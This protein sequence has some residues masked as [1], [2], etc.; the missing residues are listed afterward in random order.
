MPQIV[1]I[2]TVGG[3]RRNKNDSVEQMSSGCCDPDTSPADRSIWATVDR[4]VLERQTKALFAK[5]HVAGRYA[6]PLRPD[7]E[8]DSSYPIPYEVEKSLADDLAFIA[9]AQPQVQYVTAVALEQSQSKPSLVIRLAA[10]EG[11]SL[12]VRTKFEEIRNVLAK[13]ARKGD[14]FFAAR[15]FMIAELLNRN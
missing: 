5:Q 11:A 8:H 14:S 2:P 13:H 1:F 7:S 4:E 3:L 6:Y 15:Y 12:D 9:A 10:N